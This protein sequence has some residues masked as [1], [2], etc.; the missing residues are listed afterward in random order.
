[1][2]SGNGVEGMASGRNRLTGK[3]LVIYGT[4]SGCSTREDSGNGL[5]SWA[6]GDFGGERLGGLSWAQ[7][8]GSHGFSGRSR[9]AGR[10]P[11]KQPGDLP[12]LVWDPDNRPD[13]PSSDA[14]D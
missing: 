14:R 12:T 3:M 7:S 8:R 6:T 13:R 10:G 5:V 1:M 2:A 4:D 11:E 9:A